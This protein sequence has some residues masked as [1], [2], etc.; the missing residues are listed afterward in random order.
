MKGFIAIIVIAV[1]F[2]VSITSVFARS[3]CCSHHGGVCGCGCCDGS[4]LSSTCAPYYPECSGN[5]NYVAPVYEYNHPTNTPVP[6]TSTP[7]PFP[8]ETLTSTDVPNQA[9]NTVNQ[10]VKGASASAGSGIGST[11]L[12]LIVISGVMSGIYFKNRKT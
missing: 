11:I 4:P 7:T 5:S 12:A 9:A 8:T 10:E 1:I 6:P 3:G 2:F